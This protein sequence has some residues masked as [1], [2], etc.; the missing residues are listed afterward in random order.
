MHEAKS[1]EQRAAR[2]NRT[3]A[4]ALLLFALCFPI[5]IP[6]PAQAEPC[7][8]TGCTGGAYCARDPRLPDGSGCFARCTFGAPETGCVGAYRCVNV[9][10]N[11]ICV[12]NDS[13]LIEGDAV[14]PRCDAGRSCPTDRAYVCASGECLIAAG[15]QCDRTSQC[16]EDAECAATAGGGKTC[17]PT[18]RSVTVDAEGNVKFEPITPTLS[19]EIPGADLSAPTKEG[20][21]VVISFLGQYINA[22]YR[23]AVAVVLIVAIVMVVYGG[24]RYLVGAS[25][26]DIQA[27][28]KIIIDAIMGMLI[29]LGAYMILNTVNPDTVNFKSLSLLSVDRIDIDTIMETTEED[30]LAPFTA[31]GDGPALEGGASASS[32]FTDCPLELDAP[33]PNPPSLAS[34]RTREF[35][36]EI[37]TVVPATSARD[38]VLAI[39]EAASKCGISLGSCGKTASQIYIAA[40]AGTEGNSRGRQTHTV[41]Q[42]DIRFMDEHKCPRGSPSG[43][44]RAAAD[45]V[46]ERLSASITDWP[47][48]WINT[49][50]P[51][52]R[53]AIYNAN[54][55]EFGM[56]TAIF[57]GWASPGRA[58]VVQGAWGKDVRGGT[59]C[60]SSECGRPYPLVRTFIVRE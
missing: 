36:A 2:K 22:I 4:A 13:P 51:G 24:F 29:V 3:V 11:G 45:L 43:C 41:S 46:Y 21:N 27:G 9:S 54:S 33:T 14:N 37:G 18:T 57:M 34:P 55:S 19:V 30:T 1:K 38:R 40:G 26:G 58:Q 15:Q 52:D 17:N 28:K 32:V 16:Q 23:Y 56:H 59:I 44:T 25:I 47:N 42:A 6:A 35:L 7:P 10:G 48:A 8:A 31:D 53:F 12:F 50:E 5:L 20:D 49:L 39:A 60:L